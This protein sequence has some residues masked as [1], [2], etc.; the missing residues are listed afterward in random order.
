ME[1]TLVPIEYGME[2]IVVGHKDAI[3]CKINLLFSYVLYETTYLKNCFFVLFVLFDLFVSYEFS[4]LICLST[5]LVEG[6]ISFLFFVW[7]HAQWKVIF[8]KLCDG[9]VQTFDVT[10]EKEKG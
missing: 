6:T 4:C 8:L 10:L 9:H 3:S 5:C 7:N 1:E 2:F